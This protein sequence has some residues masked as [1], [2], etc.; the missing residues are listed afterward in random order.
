[1]VSEAGIQWQMSKYKEYYDFYK[2]HGV[3]VTCGQ[4][5]AEKGRVRCWRCLIYRREKALESRNKCSEEKRQDFLSVQ[6]EKAAIARAERKEKG[7]CPNCGRERLN[8]AYVLC[9]KCRASAKK[10][11]E[12]KRRRI[13]MMPND[14]RGDGIFCAV[15]LKPVETE[16]AKLCNRCAVNCSINGK[17]AKA[18]QDNTNHP[19]RQCEKET[20]GGTR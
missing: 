10:S 14:L 17:K 13:G 7:L 4:E 12:K 20:E 16:G 3:C 19:W 9:E 11:E 8:K 2:A 5:K 6:R 15:C 18:A 1:M